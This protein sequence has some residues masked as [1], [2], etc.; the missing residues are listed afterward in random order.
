MGADLI[1]QVLSIDEDKEPDWVAARDWIANV[2]EKAFD[3]ELEDEQD[4]RDRAHA[5]LHELESVWKGERGDRSITGPFKLRDAKVL[6]CGGTSWG[7]SPS[8]LFDMISDLD[9]I[10]ALMKAGFD[11][12]NE[13]TFLTLRF[14]A[15]GGG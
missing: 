12:A 1:I 14:D 5:H 10:G 8:E 15:K 13:P 4:A 7:D 2:E 3:T 9:S 11:G 6:I